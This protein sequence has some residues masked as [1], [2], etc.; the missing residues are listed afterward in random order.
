MAVGV[1]SHPSP[2]GTIKIWAGE[3]LLL[4]EGGVFLAPRFNHDAASAVE[5]VKL[6][7]PSLGS[8]RLRQL[9]A[10]DREFQR[11]LPNESVDR[12]LIMFSHAEMAMGRPYD[13]PLLSRTVGR[14]RLAR[15][16]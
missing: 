12:V 11:N 2:P 5:D 3:L 7:K 9:K 16:G 14:R 1:G 6:Q 15:R 13:L 10:S 8:I 4:F